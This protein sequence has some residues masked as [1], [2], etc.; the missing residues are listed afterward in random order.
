MGSVVTM[1]TSC[2]PS[3]PDS[4]PLKARTAF[5]SSSCTALTTNG[6]RQGFEFAK[7]PKDKHRVF[8]SQEGPL[9]FM[10]V[11][12]GGVGA[13]FLQS[14]SLTFACTSLS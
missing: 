14:A 11:T 12:S 6:H 8:W 1:R 10:M 2:S 7:R 3:G 4:T 9:A 5:R 13:L